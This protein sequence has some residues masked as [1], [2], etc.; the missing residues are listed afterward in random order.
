MIL[1]IKN[2]EDYKMTWCRQK[3]SLE[4]MY[5][6]VFLFSLTLVNLTLDRLHLSDLMKS[7]LKRV[8]LSH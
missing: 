1:V 8:H 3:Q 7:P 4:Y 2:R 5:I 6:H